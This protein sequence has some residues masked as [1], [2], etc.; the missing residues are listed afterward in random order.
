MTIG[1]RQ[2]GRCQLVGDS[3]LVAVGGAATGW[4][5]LVTSGW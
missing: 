3:W 2:V 5:W 4:W 1:Q